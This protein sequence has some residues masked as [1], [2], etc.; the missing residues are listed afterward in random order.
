MTSFVLLLIM[1]RI[2]SLNVNGLRNDKKR[3]MV[4]NH[5]IREKYDIICLQETHSANID[6]NLWKSQWGGDIIFS[7]GERDS[8]GVAV[9]A[10]RRSGIKLANP[11]CDN[12]GRIL[13]C[14]FFWQSINLNLLNIYTPNDVYSSKKINSK[15]I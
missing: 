2:V 11:D 6:E 7:H 12:H 8:R 1:L 9:L 13:T 15:Y 5:L 3:E 10:S 14:D 4:F